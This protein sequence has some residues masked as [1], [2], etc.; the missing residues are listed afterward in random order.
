MS[1]HLFGAIVTL[2][3]ASSACSPQTVEKPT[4][5]TA[6]MET[7]TA[8]PEGENT[9]VPTSDYNRHSNFNGGPDS[10]ADGHPGSAIGQC[11]G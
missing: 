11:F 2:L 1:A 5:V 8:P 10:H 4:E 6:T 3:L 9:R 7:D